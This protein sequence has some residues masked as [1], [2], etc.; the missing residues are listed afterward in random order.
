MDNYKHIA[1]G[2]R[3]PAFWQSAHRHISVERYAAV[4][5]LWHIHESA[6]DYSIDSNHAGSTS[7]LDVKSEIASHMLESC[8]LCEHR[9][10]ANRQAGEVG[11]CGIRRDSHYF[12]EQILWGEEPPLVPSHEVFFSGCNLR[13]KFCYSWQSLQH[14]DLGD[15]VVPEDFAKLISAR[16]AEGSINLNLIGGEPTCHLP[17]ILR[18]LQLLDTPVLIVWNSNFFMSNQTM[19]LLDGIVD[20]YLGDFKFGCNACA[21]D[22]GAVNGYVSIAKRNFKLAYESG[23]LIIRHLLLPG[24]IDCCLIPIAK[25]V[26]ENLPGVPFNLMF[27]YTPYFGALDD[28]ALCRSLL[29]D[30]EKR[31]L[32]IVESYGLNT[33]SWKKPLYAAC[34]NDRSIG[35]GEISTTVTIRP[36]GRVG[37]LH[38][39]S[40]LLDVIRALECGGKH[41]GGTNQEIK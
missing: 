32:E 41:N 14:S 3:L 7:L 26:S 19:R 8:N 27:Q 6:L 9:C 38:L 25:W 40:E 21:K 10:G 11:I 4:E 15:C 5:E 29:P 28:P 23:D 18:T 17:T 1:T 24:H 22:L 37:I 12:F 31:A 16:H 34:C 35:K 39:H 2:K 33:R 20:L 36:D 30:E 13:C